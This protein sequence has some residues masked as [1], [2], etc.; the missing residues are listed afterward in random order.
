M[1]PLMPN[2]PDLPEFPSFAII[3]GHVDIV[4]EMMRFS[5]GVPFDQLSTGPVTLDRLKAGGVRAFVV[6]FYCPDI[7]NGPHSASLHLQS[8]FDYADS[9]L[10]GLKAIRALED[11]DACCG[12]CRQ[13]IGSAQCIDPVKST[14]PAE[15]AGP[16]GILFLI[17]NADALLEMDLEALHTRAI[18]VVGLTHAGKN[19]LG[20]GNGVR[21]PEGLTREGRQL[22]RK[23]RNEGFALDVAHLSDPSFRDL[24]GIFDGPM[25]SSHTGFRFFCDKPRNVDR[26][27]LRIIFERKGIVGVT[28]NPEMLSVNEKAGIED[29][30]RHI[31]WVVQ[32]YGPDHVAL[33]SDF[34]GFDMASQGLEDISRFPALAALLHHYG[35]PPYAIEKIMGRNWYLFHASLLD[36]R[37]V[38]SSP[39]TATDTRRSA[40]PGWSPVCVRGAAPVSTGR[41]EDN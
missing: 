18:K 11:L 32:H 22:V 20:D 21:N 2:G 28:V 39:T 23:L 26:E 16:P 12:N 10:A 31:D 36:H 41:A 6:A 1:Q 30:F 7:H 25:I 37:I 29:V 3:D 38:N 15:P 13:S 34:C 8:L 19:R 27:H 17:E 4:Y 40:V 33:G 9:H 5:F 35:Y 24:I 14:T